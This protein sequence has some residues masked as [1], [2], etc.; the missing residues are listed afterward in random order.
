MAR[1]ATSGDVTINLAKMNLPDRQIPIRVRLNDGA[2]ADIGQIRLLP[3]PARNGPVP[4]MNVADVSFGAGPATIT[5]YDRSRNIT[6]TADRGNIPLGDAVKILNNLPA[7][8][9]LPASVRPVESGEAEI[10]SS[11]VSGFLLAMLIGIFCIYALL[12][13]LFHDV[14]QPITIL[15]ALPPSAGG[16]FLMLWLM[17]MDLS[18][19]SLIGLLMLM[20]IVTKN[21][22]LLVEYAVMARRERGMGRQ[23]ALIDACSKRARPIIM[24][25]IAMAAGM[26]PITLGL[27][28]D[29]SFRAPMGAAVIGGLFASTGLSLF[30]VP[31]IYTL[32]DDFEHWVKRLFGRHPKPVP[33]VVDAGK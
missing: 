24:T 22:I 31:V 16:A 23:E 10:L 27:S 15:S 33:V 7:M 8:K 3:V 18:L 14:L 9:N 26:L 1:I 25:T 12:V 32:M 20:G 21:S 17:G 6:I 28:G 4:L 29:A 19:P 30:V 2:R 5:R 13:L 11:I